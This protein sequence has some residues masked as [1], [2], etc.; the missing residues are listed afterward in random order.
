MLTIHSYF[1][2]AP[3]HSDASQSSQAFFY[4]EHLKM[5]R[6]ESHIHK[7]IFKMLFILQDDPSKTASALRGNFYIT[8]DRGYMDEDGYFWFVA[9]SDD[10]ILSSG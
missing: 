4:F 8:G 7:N 3:L 6:K 5:T 1:T 2:L 9:R 10:I